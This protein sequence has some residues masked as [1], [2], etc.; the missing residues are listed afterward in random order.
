[1]VS[2][3]IFLA[4]LSLVVMGSPSYLV[5][6][7]L[8]LGSLEK[9]KWKALETVEPSMNPI[10]FSIVGIGATKGRCTVNGL[11]KGGP[12][13]AGYI[14]GD[15][16]QTPKGVLFSGPIA[17]PRKVETLSNTN[18]TYQDVLKSYLKRN[19]VTTTARLTKVVRVDLDGDGSQEVI[20]E[21]SNRDGLESIGTPGN[22]PGDYSLVLLRYVSKGKVVEYP[23]AFDHPKT[24]ELSYLNRLEAI[25]DFDGNGTMDVV[26]SSRYYEG[27][28]AKLFGFKKGTV[29]KLVEMGDGA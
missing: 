10:E 6:D 29:S 7:H 24:E 27:H 14:D 11:I 13:D 9:S 25:G 4:G 20:L 26:V 3:M 28:S 16:E 15:Y 19:K 1:M 21:A 8:V 18:S 2:Q 12:N 17:Y 23:L 5:F 22:K